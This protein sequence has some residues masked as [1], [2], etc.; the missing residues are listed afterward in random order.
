MRVS[1]R[2]QISLE[3]MLIMGIM[4]VMLAYSINSATF[5]RDSPSYQ[6]LQLQVAVE[7]KNLASSISNA[8]SQVYSMGPGSKATT[9]VKIN[10]LRRANY[11]RKAWNI[12]DP[13]VFITYGPNG[14]RNG[15]YVVVVN[16]TG[17]ANLYLTGDE[18]NTFW[19]PSLAPIDCLENQTCWE[20]TGL[21]NSVQVNIG[22]ST[23][24]FYGLKIAP[25]AIPSELKIVVEWNPDAK[26]YFSFNET[27][28]EIKININVGG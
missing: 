8:M 2:G 7:E 14:D 26:T 16:G 4:I 25:D 3:F 12:E 27:T 24:T 21:G 18:K 13:V 28:G 6:T 22:G 5:S 11:L 17:T 9:Y 15:T 10:Y 19:S 1:R 20:D 23:K